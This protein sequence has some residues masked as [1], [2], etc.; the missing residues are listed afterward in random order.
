[1]VAAFEPRDGD[2]RDAEM[3]GDG[4]W[5]EAFGLP[6]RPQVAVV[7]NGAGP[8]EQSED[9]AGDGSFEKPQNLFFGAK[10]RGDKPR[11]GRQT[12]TKAL[13]PATSKSNP[14]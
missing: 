11:H 7:V 3:V 12:V 13:K 6:G 5:G 14:L 9:F 1:L 10:A 8:G 2:Y 4:G